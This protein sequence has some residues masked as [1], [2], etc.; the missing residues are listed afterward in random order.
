MASSMLRWSPLLLLLLL[1]G[2]V[3]GR[4]VVRG[5]LHVDQH[6]SLAHSRRTGETP[7]DITGT[8]GENPEAVQELL[9]Y[10]T[11]LRGEAIELTIEAKTAMRTVQSL[12][13]EV[14]R[15]VSR[16]NKEAHNVSVFL[17]AAG[18]VHDRTNFLK[19]EQAG[20]N[21]TLT[22]LRAGLP[23]AEAE[24]GNL[25]AA[26]GRAQL[27]F[28][29]LPLGT[30]CCNTT[31]RI[32]TS[33]ECSLAIKAL[34]T[35]DTAQINWEGLSGEYPGG[36]SFHDLAVGGGGNFN[37]AADSAAAHSE[38]VPLCRKAVAPASAAQLA[39]WSQNISR[40]N[41]EI[42]QFLPGGEVSV[43][44]EGLNGNYT[45]YRQKISAVVRRTFEQNN[46]Y[47]FKAYE[48]AQRRTLAN[49]SSIVGGSYRRPCALPAE[50]ASR[51]LQ[52]VT[53]GKWAWRAALR[54]TRGCV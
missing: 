42:K 48:E 47:E 50:V 51:D 3:R 17:A 39:E 34:Y 15:L 28:Y 20:E 4:S 29:K 27:I 53:P 21:R 37:T 41:T 8:I 26:E 7:T 36:C 40:L 16:A 35:G 30:C 45:V 9:N 52:G 44:M 33:E 5:F 32:A 49:L 54:T 14:A 31:D 38:M 46:S 13:R 19:Q 1:V 2:L 23:K 6:R 18:H 22:W 25:A 11:T 12:E 43:Q 10:S 24:A